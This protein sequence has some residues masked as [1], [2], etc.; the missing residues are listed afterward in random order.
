[1][2][3]AWWKVQASKALLDWANNGK[4]SRQ[5]HLRST[6]CLKLVKDLTKLSKFFLS[7]PSKISLKRK[8]KAWLIKE[9]RRKKTNQRSLLIMLP[10]ANSSSLSKKLCQLLFRHRIWSIDLL[11]MLMCK[12]LKF[13]KE[14]VLR[15][16][17]KSMSKISLQHQPQ[18]FW[19]HLT[20]RN[21]WHRLKNL[22][23]L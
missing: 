4:R 16:Q 15:S 2:S 3:S 9:L 19:S 10:I 8:G 6:N 23:F 5:E 13:W 21:R 1:M 14:F 18:S 7:L 17:K 11:S 22:F 12:N 20:L